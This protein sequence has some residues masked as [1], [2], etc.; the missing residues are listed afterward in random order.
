[1]SVNYLQAECRTLLRQK[2]DS[3]E[4]VDARVNLLLSALESI[5]PVVET[6]L[7]HLY[8]DEG[9]ADE[10]CPT[11]NT[12][13]FAKTVLDRELREAQKKGLSF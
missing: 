5:M 12:G 8:P 7:V 6:A 9:I 3:G 4:L 13:K 1:M 2:L 11:C 10:W